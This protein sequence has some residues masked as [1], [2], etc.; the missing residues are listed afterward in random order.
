MRLDADLQ[1]GV[2][3]KLATKTDS[4]FLI[5]GHKGLGMNE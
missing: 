4:V 3:H 5:L 2:S 1:D